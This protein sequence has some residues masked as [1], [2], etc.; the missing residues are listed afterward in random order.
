MLLEHGCDA[1]INN[2]R[3][4]TAIALC[5]GNENMV[6]MRLLLKEIPFDLPPTRNNHFVYYLANLACLGHEEMDFV[7][8]K[9]RAADEKILRT[10]LHK[11]DYRG[12]Q[13]LISVVK[14]FT[15]TVH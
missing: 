10:E 12:L 5:I 8:Q 6:G 9:L 3:G 14:S 13:L 7:L 11:T 2:D 15:E 4:E 1:L